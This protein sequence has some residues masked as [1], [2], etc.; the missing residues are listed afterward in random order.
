M[1]LRLHYQTRKVLTP[2][3]PFT[4]QMFIAVP[5]AMSR[6]QSKE[7][8]YVKKFLFMAAVALSLS[9]CDKLEGATAPADSTSGVASGVVAVAS[10]AQ[11]YP[12]G[13]ISTTTISKNAEIGV[14]QCMYSPAKNYALTVQ[15]DG[16]IVV[17]RVSNGVVGSAAWD[18]R[19]NH[20]NPAFR[21]VRLVMQADG[22]LVGYTKSDV[23]T[24]QTKTNN[25]WRW[26]Y[27]VIP[28]S[29]VPNLFLLSMQNDGNLVV[30][31]TDDWRNPHAIW[32]LFGV[33]ASKMASTRNTNIF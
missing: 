8:S 18:A 21:T 20:S 11:G 17:N 22:N 14:G 19:T 9:G 25:T 30:Y 6:Y 1:T 23:W 10:A 26:F 33:P 5:F 32:A 29:Y 13:C 16:N 27:N 31:S 12:N 4:L 2:P 3:P 15:S 7:G 24:W 28:P